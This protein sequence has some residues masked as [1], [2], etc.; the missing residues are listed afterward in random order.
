MNSTQKNKF[1]FEVTKMLRTKFYYLYI[2]NTLCYVKFNF[3]ITA[4]LV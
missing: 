4:Q 1:F 2:F 3:D